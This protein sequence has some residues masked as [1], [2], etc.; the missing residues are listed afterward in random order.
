M[1]PARLNAVSIQMN[2]FPQ[3]A[4]QSKM[5]DGSVECMEA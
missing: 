3:R 4:L 2:C 1:I 5:D